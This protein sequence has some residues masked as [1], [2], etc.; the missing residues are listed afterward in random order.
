MP[1]LI[2]VQ[3]DKIV[4][5]ENGEIVKLEVLLLVLQINFVQTEA[6]TSAE[7]EQKTVT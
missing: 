1:L 2:V 5:M 4:D 7:Q 3:E 6:A